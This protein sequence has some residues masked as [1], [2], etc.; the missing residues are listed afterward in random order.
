VNRLRVEVMMSQVFFQILGAQIVVM[1]MVPII[2]RTIENRFYAGLT[3][4]SVFIALGLFIVSRGW[5]RPEI[6][7]TPTFVA[8]CIFLFL[9]ALPMVLSRV[10]NSGVD[11]RE[12]AVWGMPGPVFHRLSTGFFVVMMLAT[13]FDAVRFWRRERRISKSARAS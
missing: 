11:F 9:I 6:R 12:V 5:R 1:A 10:M 8:G 7:R 3:A 13:L 4:G 2:F